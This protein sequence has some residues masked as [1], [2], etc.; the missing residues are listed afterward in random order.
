M[1][2]PSMHTTRPNPLAESPP[3]AGG[4]QTVTV[5]APTL[6]L[7]QKT[8]ITLVLYVTQDAG[9][10]FNRETPMTAP[11]ANTTA[12]VS[13]TFPALAGA[14]SI[15]GVAGNELLYTQ[16]LQAG[17]TLPNDAPGPTSSLAVHQNRLFV[18]LTD[19]QGGYRYSQQV[20][21]GVGLQWNGTLGGTTP[22]DGGAI[23]GF[24]DMDDLVLI[25]CERKIYRVTG[26]G[27]TPSGGYDTYS[28]PVE[29]P[30]DTGCSDARSI[31]KMPNG[32]VFKSDKGW[33]RVGRDLTVSYIGAAVFA[34]D[35]YDVFAACYIEDR[36][37]ARFSCGFSFHYGTGNEI[38][39]ML[40]YSY[41]DD[42]WS[43]SSITVSPAAAADRTLLAYDGIWWPVLGVYVSISLA[44][45]LCR[46]TPGVFSDQ[47]PSG[48]TAPVVM[49]ARTSFLHLPQLEGYQ[50]VR[51]LYI[52][53]SFT[54][55]P[56]AVSGLDILVD[57]DDVYSAVTGSTTT[58]QYT[59]TGTQ[60]AATSGTGRTI[61]FRHKL[62]KQK[63]KSVA[64]TFTNSTSFSSWAGITGLEAM[65]LEIGAKRG[66]NRLSA[67][68][69][70]A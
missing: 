28:D 40:V 45:G 6:H 56:P 19:T 38:G 18:D 27:P 34:Y 49:T 23:V 26:T 60:L 21:P 25:F 37:E 14:T 11:L 65:A 12:A 58:G 5:T 59:A 9:T 54:G 24:A 8:G 48:A 20:I 53:G 61:D 70:V 35:A 32:V 17:T 68:Q 31:L 22:V 1:S 55:A 57:F 10:I 30:S 51:W 29:I 33:H 62:H 13:V 15:T 41:L 7:S 4:N 69:T 67:A 64:F 16:P 47:I 3:V 52:T 50:R 46:D 63:C 44:D 36:K 43:V 2:L 66:V 39:V 42:Q